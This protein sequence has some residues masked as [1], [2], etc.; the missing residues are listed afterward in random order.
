MFAVACLCPSIAESN[1]STSQN[2]IGKLSGRAIKHKNYL[3]NRTLDEA[4]RATSN[5]PLCFLLS[6]AHL[7]YPLRT[8]AGMDSLGKLMAV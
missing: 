3:K 5:S 6:F 8:K 4:D 2:F 1:K 7:L